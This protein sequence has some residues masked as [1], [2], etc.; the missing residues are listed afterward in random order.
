[1]PVSAGIRLFLAVQGDIDE[2]FASRQDAAED[3]EKDLVERLHH[4]RLPS[5]IGDGRGRLLKGFG[6]F[7]GRALRAW[8]PEDRNGD[9]ASWQA[10]REIFMRYPWLNPNIALTLRYARDIHELVSER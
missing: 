6:V 2:T 3:G 1:V 4:L 7:H 5:R 9:G 10:P 8:F